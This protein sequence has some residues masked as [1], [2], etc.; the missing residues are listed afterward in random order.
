MTIDQYFFL[1]QGILFYQT[2]P[3]MLVI[4]V[5]LGISK[6]FR[7][8][9]MSLVIPSYVPLEKLAAASGLQMVVNGIILLGAGPILG[10]LNM[11]FTNY[12]G[13]MNN[14]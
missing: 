1:F 4:A 3:S 7:T 14:Y 12:K 13:K 5:L 9:Y 10:K 6:G 2:Y 11:K 8:V